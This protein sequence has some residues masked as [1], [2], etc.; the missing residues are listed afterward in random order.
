MWAEDWQEIRLKEHK[1]L[2]EKG[3][4]GQAKEFGL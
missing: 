2:M 1:E 4:V 3:P